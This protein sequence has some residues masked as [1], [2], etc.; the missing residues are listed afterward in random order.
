MYI[1]SPEHY[2]FSLN[3]RLISSGKG[4]SIGTSG[5]SSLCF[6]SVGWLLGVDILSYC[7]AN[8]QWPS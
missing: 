8:N 6:R 5:I 3:R 7:L 4:W 1:S 2:E